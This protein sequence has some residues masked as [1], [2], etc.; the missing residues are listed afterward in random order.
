MNNN[1]PEI[2]KIQATKHFIHLL[3][4]MKEGKVEVRC[5]KPGKGVLRRGWVSRD[6][7]KDPEQREA[8]FQVLSEYNGGCQIYVTV[9]A[10]DENVQGSVKDSDVGKRYFLPFDFDPL[11]ED[12]AHTNATEEEKNRAKA[13]CEWFINELGIQ[14]DSYLKT[15]SGNGYFLLIDIE[16]L[17][18]NDENGE[19]ITELY[20]YWK[21]KVEAKFPSVDFDATVRNPA[22]IMK[23][24]GTRSIK[25]PDVNDK[26]QRLC[27]IEEE[28][29]KQRTPVD[30]FTLLPKER[31]FSWADIPEPKKSSGLKLSRPLPTVNFDTDRIGEGGSCSC[32]GDA[33]S[34]CLEG[35]D[36]GACWRSESWSSLGE[37]GI[38]YIVMNTGDRGTAFFWKDK[39][40]I[41][42]KMGEEVEPSV[43]F[44]DVFETTE[45]KKEEKET[46]YSKQ[47]RD[48]FLKDC[49]RFLAQN[50]RMMK[51]DALAFQA[52]L[53]LLSLLKH[54][55]PRMNGKRCNPW[56]LTIAPSGT[57]KSHLWDTV[58]ALYDEA[59]IPSN[60]ERIRV[61]GKMSIEGFISACNFHPDRCF[62]FRADE[63]KVF[64][65]DNTI[66]SL[67]PSMTSWKSG[68][69]ASTAYKS[70]SGKKFGPKEYSEVFQSAEDFQFQLLAQSTLGWLLDSITTSEVTGGFLGRFLTVQD[71]WDEKERPYMLLSEEMYAEACSL[72]DGKVDKDR[73]V[74]KAFKIHNLSRHIVNIHWN[75]DVNKV[76]IQSVKNAM[77]R[78]ELLGDEMYMALVGR[79]LSVIE[80]VVYLIE[81]SHI[82][83]KESEIQSIIDYVP[84]SDEDFT[85]DVLKQLPG[86]KVED[87]TVKDSGLG[88][89]IS[90][91]EESVREAVSFVIPEFFKWF[92]SIETNV[93]LTVTGQIRNKTL[94][95]LDKNFH[96]KAEWRDSD[97]GKVYGMTISELRRSVRGLDTMKMCREVL[98]D[99]AEEG[100]YTLIEVK[101]VSNKKKTQLI[102]KRKEDDDRK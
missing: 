88:I 19:F 15:M 72:Y 29:N 22:R 4:P 100:I 26:P 90:I 97:K 28:L 76:L 53:A 37:E 85:P 73:I 87:E 43:S 1:I 30:A 44:S 57:G 79:L 64:R 18:N 92:S 78:Y 65:D 17:E 32:C 47:I 16:P 50:Q 21:K 25:G 10:V 84:V 102:T 60:S 99:I 33:S 89:E 58:Q 23:L 27:Q 38:D 13:A 95:Y 24:A 68:A 93:G 35:P 45:K 9:N 6:T 42:E 34:M 77:N 46:F 12:K 82:L 59:L 14:S 70:N 8:F 39:T 69:Y 61:S 63:Y 55:G 81:L 41:Y 2:N 11:R 74:E 7:L 62:V 20:A 67:V 91:S 96:S 71:D 94:S 36:W 31:V 56:F 83:S 3:K 75:K 51:G 101:T 48:G 5:I 86:F 49:T 66:K 98:T 52:T 40:P 54:N 80:E